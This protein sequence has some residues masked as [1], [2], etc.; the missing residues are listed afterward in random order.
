MCKKVIRVACSLRSKWRLNGNEWALK[1]HCIQSLP[2]QTP[3]KWL[4]TACDGNGWQC[5]TKTYTK[6]KPRR[7]F[8]KPLVPVAVDSQKEKVAGDGDVNTSA[9]NLRKVLERV[10]KR[11]RDNNQKRRTKS[12]EAHDAKSNVVTFN[13]HLENYVMMHPANALYRMLNTEWIVQMRIALQFRPRVH[14]ERFSQKQVAHR[15]RTV[16]FT[17]P[18]ESTRNGGTTKIVGTRRIFS[19]VIAVNQ[20]V[21]WRASKGWA[22]WDTRLLTRLN[23]P[24][25]INLEVR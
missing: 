22:L 18:S 3:L 9:G 23:R 16:T 7:F 10:H 11:V 14:K 20:I 15:S 6:L 1:S 2:N 8:L 25:W 19:F 24:Q 17:I 4:G 12:Q 5:R 21:S 13:I